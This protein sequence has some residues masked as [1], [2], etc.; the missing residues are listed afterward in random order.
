[1]QK[2]L[3]PEV[4]YVSEQ[5]GAAAHLCACGCGSK[6]RTPLGPTE[7]SVEET[8]EGEHRAVRDD[9]GIDVALPLEVAEDDGFAVGA[10]PTPALEPARPEETLV[11]LDDPKQLALGF[12]GQQHALQEALLHESELA[13]R[14]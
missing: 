8:L 3:Q 13:A 11:D 10:A 1:M 5:F 4:L 12:A 2:D 6:V 14:G 7:W 9:L